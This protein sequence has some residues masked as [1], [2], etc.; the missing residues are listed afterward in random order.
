MKKLIFLAGFCLACFFS[1]G[2]NNPSPVHSVNDFEQLYFSKVFPF[3]KISDTTFQRLKSTIVFDELN[4]FRGFNYV[5][6][7]KKE[8]SKKEYEKFYTLMVGKEFVE[9]TDKYNKKK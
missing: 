5:G 7:L 9:A 2:Q 3:N 4:Q 1:Q 8:L 6:G